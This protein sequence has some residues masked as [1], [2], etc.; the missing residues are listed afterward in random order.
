MTDGEK[1]AY[2]LGWMRGATDALLCALGLS[3]GAE[4]RYECIAWQVERAA[5]SRGRRAFFT[6]DP[7]WPDVSR[8]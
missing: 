5:E 3:C 4:E 7:G 1:A 8:G 6:V 2:S